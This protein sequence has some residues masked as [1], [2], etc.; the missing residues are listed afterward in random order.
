VNPDVALA[1][2][3]RALQVRAGKTAEG[4]VHLK[5]ALALGTANETSYFLYAYELISQPGQDDARLKQASEA[6]QRAIALRP[7]YTEAKLLL[8]YVYLSSGEYGSARDLLA[9]VV[10]AERSNHR[11][12]LRLAEA[13]VSLN[14]FA[15]ARNVLGPVMARTTDTAE[16]ERAR[17]LLGRSVEMETGRTTRTDPSRD[18]ASGTNTV[19][20]VFR[21]LADGE[22]RDTGVFEAVECGPKG[23]V[24]V[25]RTAQSLLRTRAARFEDVEFLAYRALATQSISCGSQ[26]PAMEVYLTWRPPSGSSDATEGT[27]VAI[28]ILPEQ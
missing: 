16:R 14:E 21:V 18:R 23:L 15:A 10:R 3:S 25:V 20:P 6:L 22:R 11:A 13:L 8:G 26:V 27:T 9:P 5:Q 2:S 19:I 12:A 7:G 4:M 1:H 28:E 24:F 17:T